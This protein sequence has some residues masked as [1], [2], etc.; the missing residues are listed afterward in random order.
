MSEDQRHVSSNQHRLNG[1]LFAG[2]REHLPKTEHVADYDDRN[3]S[4]EKGSAILQNG[5]YD[6]IDNS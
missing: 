3:D 1:S 6:D 4:L 2:S 5:R